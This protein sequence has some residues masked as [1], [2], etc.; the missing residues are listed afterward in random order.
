MNDSKAKCGFDFGTSSTSVAVINNKTEIAGDREFTCL[1]FP[2]AV[3]YNHEEGGIDFG[4]NAIKSYL[5][6]IPGRL[7][8]SFKS[9]LGSST[10]DSGTMIQGKMTAYETV[11][12]TYVSHVK[13]QMEN[14]LGN[15]LSSV[16]IGRPVQFVDDDPEADSKAQSDLE[17]VFRKCGFENIEF[18]FEPVAA[19]MSY[20]AQKEQGSNVILTVDIGGGTT[21]LSVITPDSAYGED[22]ERAKVSNTTGIHLGG[23]DFDKEISMRSV[24]TLLGLGS[25]FRHKPTLSIPTH[26]FFDMSQ[27]NSIHNLYTR[28]SMSTIQDLSSQVIDKTGLQ[29]MLKVIRDRSGHRILSSVEEAKIV[30]SDADSAQ[31][32][33][34]F[35]DS[36]CSPQ[37]YQHDLKS[38]LREYLEK[39]TQSIHDLLESCHVDLGAVDFVV[40]TGGSSKIPA[41]KNHLEELF[42]AEKIVQHDTFHSVAKGLALKADIVF[43]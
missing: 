12:V 36:E 2:S 31:I 18:E 23:D 4:Q 13:Q 20:V 7:M 38:A 26:Y 10:Y 33:L 15:E 29:R 39:I 32:D 17:K 21:D 8:K 28:D 5:D 6:L 24:M 35:V 37:I 30:L 43:A 9:L 1:T 19:S 27:W 3:F 25:Y 40:C 34:S 41:I 14:R 22:G 42:G 16:V 11:L